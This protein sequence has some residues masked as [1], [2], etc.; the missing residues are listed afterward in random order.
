MSQFTNAITKLDSDYQRTQEL[1]AR[2]DKLV[3]KLDDMN[4]QYVV[5]L[6]A[7]QLLVTVSDANTTAVLD[8]ITGVVNK[9]LAE[10]FPHD[11][12]RIFLEK[13][14]YQGIHAHINIKL[15]GSNGKVRD[16]TLQSGTGLRQIISFLF[17]LSM[18]EIRKGR[19]IFIMD[20]LL[21]G[22]HPKAKRIAL[23]ILQI[24]ASEGFQFVM[25]E[26]GADSIGKL[27][28]VEKPDTVASV[29]PFAGDTYNN[30][31]FV[32]N[33]P[34]EDVDLGAMYDA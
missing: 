4:K 5:M 25:V 16:L 33:R 1:K 21:S 6:E 14:M 10:L 34:A 23:E 27:Y 12:R 29:T 8:Y 22:L 31:V 28:I 30:E 13:T 19:R 17:V 11:S 20:E 26:Y 18:I 2:L 3:E 24:F 15:T 9:A 32:F 7:Q